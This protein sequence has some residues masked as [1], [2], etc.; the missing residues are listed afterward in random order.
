VAVAGDNP[1]TQ[2]FASSALS[3]PMAGGR[4][5]LWSTIRN[6]LAQCE[7]DAG[8]GDGGLTTAEREELNRGHEITQ[9]MAAAAM[10]AR[11]CLQWLQRVPPEIGEAREAVSRILKIYVD[12]AAGY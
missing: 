9:P 4:P 2:G 7:R 10:N 11:V 1:T 8:R 12:R 5:R 6:W 3:N